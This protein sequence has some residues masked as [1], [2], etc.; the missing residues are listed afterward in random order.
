[1][2]IIKELKYLQDDVIDEIKKYKKKY[3]D[4]RDLE[5][6]LVRSIFKSGYLKKMSSV[7]IWADSEV[8]HMYWFSNPDKLFYVVF[9]NYVGSCEACWNNHYEK[10]N[11]YY[12]IKHNI[13][14]AY[15][16]KDYNDAKEY[17]KKLEKQIENN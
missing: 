13:S 11:F 16:T 7:G 15:I 2:S 4:I 8:V 9:S 1:M 6:F 10:I 5:N 3:P 12:M 14:K 17:F